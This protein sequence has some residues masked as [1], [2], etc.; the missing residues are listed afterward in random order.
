MSRKRQNIIHSIPFDTVQSC[1][2]LGQPE[3]V[4]DLLITGE[5]TV[6]YWTRI[7]HYTPPTNPHS[8]TTSGNECHRG[9]HGLTVQKQG[10]VQL[11]CPSTTPKVSMGSPYILYSYYIL[12][13]HVGTI[14]NKYITLTFHVFIYFFILIQIHYRGGIE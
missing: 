11:V 8:P 6:N 2:S 5:K 9:V 14:Y 12:Y 13:Y 7:E 4:P 1:P 3:V 10:S